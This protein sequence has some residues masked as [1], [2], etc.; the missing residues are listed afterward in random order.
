MNRFFWTLFLIIIL[1]YTGISQEAKPLNVAIVK[2]QVS[3]GIPETYAS[4]FTDRLR[5]ELFNTGMF[6]V[7]ERNEMDEILK[8]QGFQMSG[9][10]TD[11]CFV[12]VGKILGVDHIVAG[13]VSQIGS[14]YTINL[15]LI[16]VETSKTEKAIVV[17]Y[18]GGLEELATQKIKEAAHELVEGKLVYSDI[19]N[20]QLIELAKPNTILISGIETFTT[21]EYDI[22]FIKIPS[23]SFNMGSDETANDERPMHKVKIESFYLMKTELTQAIWK[24]IMGNN[25]SNF[26][27]DDL[28]VESISWEEVQEFILRLNIKDPGKNYRLPTEAEWEYACRAGTNSLFYN[29]DMESD[30]ESIAYYSNNS[31]NKTFPVGTKRANE[32]D[33]YDLTGNVWEW[34]SDWYHDNYFGAPS[35][36]KSWDTP[37]G[38]NRVIRGGSLGTDFYNCRSTKRNYYNPNKKNINIG[39]RLVCN[40]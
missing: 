18:R 11:E 13:S 3:G 24:T 15:R 35:D 37:I 29:G 17:D 32:W 14:L 8:E 33:L 23:G 25:P 9:C 31:G 2:M 40:P 20:K 22:A 36:G 30:L 16:S 5:F 4:A 39:F 10:T 21:P 1:T 19:T 26:K 28:P 7:M 34:C 12:Q 27:G 38:E 6:N